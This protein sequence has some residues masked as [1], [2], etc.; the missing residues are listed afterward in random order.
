MYA[1]CMHSVSEESGCAGNMEASG[2]T[3][4]LM[5]FKVSGQPLWDHLG[6]F[7]DLQGGRLGIVKSEETGLW[8][9]GQSRMV[10]N[11]G[12]QIGRAHV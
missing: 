8:G 4:V 1:Q 10:W 6:A 11:G 2:V 9:W 7:T 3:L 5:E 12:S